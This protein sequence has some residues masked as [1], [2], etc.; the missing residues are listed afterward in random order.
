VPETD[1]P[2]RRLPVL[3]NTPGEDEAELRPAWHWIVLTGVATLLA[4]LL[5]AS[6]VNALGGSVLAN[7]LALAASAAVAGA[8]AGR[9]GVNTGARH[10]ALGSVAT[11]AFGC[12]LAYR[13]LAGAPLTFVATLVVACSLA[14]AGALLGFRLTRRR[15]HA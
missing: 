1:R 15:G 4:W 2:R 8:M 13:A 3:Q 12:A 10:A 6:L 14:A 5:S 9:L 7:A 11:A